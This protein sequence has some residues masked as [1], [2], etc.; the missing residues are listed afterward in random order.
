ME[1]K[2]AAYNTETINWLWAEALEV[3]MVDYLALYVLDDQQPVSL[4]QQTSWQGQLIRGYRVRMA[5]V[6]ETCLL[7]SPIPAPWKWR[8]L[9]NYPTF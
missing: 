1:L 7:L 8:V 9:S 3:G 4:A 5:S 2:G 6:V